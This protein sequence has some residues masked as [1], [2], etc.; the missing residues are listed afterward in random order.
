M[1]NFFLIISSGGFLGTAIIKL[2]DTKQ[3]NV[4]YSPKKII[5]NY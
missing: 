4:Q 5:K 3:Y 1:K 2:I